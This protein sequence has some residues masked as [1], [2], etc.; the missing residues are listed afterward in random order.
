MT[1]P[2]GTI[3]VEVELVV[4]ETNASGASRFKAPPFPSVKLSVKVNESRLT[5]PVFV[6]PT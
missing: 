4:A 5:P 3:V 2:L 6:T 1:T